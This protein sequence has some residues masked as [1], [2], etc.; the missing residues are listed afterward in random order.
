MEKNWN[1]TDAGRQPDYS[2]K[3]ERAA[4][5]AKIPGH[6][7]H[8]FTMENER[9]RE[10]LAE[11]EQKLREESTA[12]EEAGPVFEKIR[13][14]SIHYAKKGDLIYP[15][16]KVK[17]GIAGPS[18][19]MW[20]DDDEIRDELSRLLRK[21]SGDA[22]WKERACKILKCMSDMIMKEEQVLF[23]I[24]AVNFAEEEWMGIYQDSKDYDK[25]LG[26]EKEIWEQAEPLQVTAAGEEGEIVMPGGH[27]S[28]EQ[29]TA[30]LNT[31]P[32]E[33]TFIDADNINRFFNEGPKAFKRPKMAID[34]EVFSCHPPKIEPL[35]RKIID[36]FRNDRK[37]SVPIW[38]EKNGRTT[39][40]TYM[41]VRD[42][43]RRYLGT[44]EFVQ[45]MEFLK[46]HFEK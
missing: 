27:M 12:P 29:L 5:L 24:C 9:L 2:N 44:A 36:D 46:Q 31:I 30:L 20:T 8:T 32:M 1:Q 19:L 6:P 34:R 23:P 25:C 7:L 28:V 22:D 15:H 17:Y 33:I 18:D 10:L 40:V 3:R 38:M 13:E 43:K 41:A 39:L 4:T 45:D 21:E 35:V 26:I 16:L 37:D 11:A 14:I 42:E